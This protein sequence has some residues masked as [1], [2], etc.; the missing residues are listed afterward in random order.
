[1]GNSV[2]PPV[3]PPFSGLADRHDL[4]TEVRNRLEQLHPR[5]DSPASSGRRYVERE[6]EAAGVRH[7][8]ATMAC[9]NEFPL[10]QFPQKQGNG[11]V[12]SHT[13]CVQRY[14]ELHRHLVTEALV[15]AS[16][17]LLELQLAHDVYA[18]LRGLRFPVSLPDPAGPGGQALVLAKRRM[19]WHQAWMHL[20]RYSTRQSWVRLNRIYVLRNRVLSQCHAWVNSARAMAFVRGLGRVARMRRSQR[21]ARDMRRRFRALMDRFAH[22]IA[23]GDLGCLSRWEARHLLWEARCWGHDNAGV[24]W[25]TKHTGLLF[26]A[27]CPTFDE[28]LALPD[29][30]ADRPVDPPPD[31]PRRPPVA[32]RVRA[33]TDP[34][35]M[36][37]WLRTKGR[38]LRYARRLAAAKERVLFATCLRD[39]YPEPLPTDGTDEDAEDDDNTIDAEV[40]VFLGLFTDPEVEEML[41]RL[42]SGEGG[43]DGGVVDARLIRRDLEGLPVGPHPPPDVGACAARFRTLAA[44]HVDRPV[45]DRAVDALGLRS[46]PGGALRELQHWIVRWFFGELC[47]DQW[48]EVLFLLHPDRY[49]ERSGSEPSGSMRRDAFDLARRAA[50]NGLP[51]ASSCPTTG[52][53]CPPDAFL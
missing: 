18:L 51:F 26:P 5:A 34:K 25:K 21:Y 23:G 28:L 36:Q 20:L 52:E 37:T 14:F 24:T 41:Q 50:K 9:G 29:P 6:R 30:S 44:L 49:G 2:A 10:G 31:V 48:R 17:A 33:L 47:L 35:H 43:S 1:M 38:R 45:V 11:P 8:D 7:R 19:D 22:D 46:L 32:T 40:L 13:R 3:N 12:E 15:H 4:P 16:L 27:P 42:T 53:A 39:L